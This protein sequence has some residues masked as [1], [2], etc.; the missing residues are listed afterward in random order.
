MSAAQIAGEDG[1]PSG[2]PIFCY[3]IRL[4]NGGTEAFYL[5]S[6][7]QGIEIEDLPAEW[8]A[9]DPQVFTPAQI[10]HGTVE[11]MDGIDK[12][13]FDMQVLLSAAQTLSRYTIF[14]AIPKIRIDVIRVMPGPL[15]AGEPAIYG[16]DTMTTQSGDIADF[17]VEGFLMKARCCPEPFMS[18]HQATRWRFTRTCNRVLY[19]PSCGV[20]RNDF[21]LVGNIL[22]LDYQKRVIVVSDQF[23]G[24][25]SEDFFRG[26]V[27]VH[28]PTG[29][30]HSIFTSA[31][32][33]AN[34]RIWLQQWNPDLQVGDVV[35]LFAG[36]RHTKD[37]CLTKFNNVANFGGFPDVPNVNPAIHGAAR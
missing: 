18:G 32:A 15:L 26:G 21:R 36:C 37:D 3:A 20:V 10:G 2:K 9:D 16:R 33:A 22:A 11:R 31:H 17:G 35:S 12:V 29:T 6:F 34:T 7:D 14:G 13:T 30:N 8:G 28:Q 23:A 19:G 4:L 5:T 27:M 25:H 24:P 1:R